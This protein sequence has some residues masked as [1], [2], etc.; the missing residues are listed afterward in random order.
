MMPPRVLASGPKPCGG[1]KALLWRKFKTQ[2]TSLDQEKNSQ[3]AS[4]NCGFFANHFC[5]QCEGIMSTRVHAVRHHDTFPIITVT[6]YNRLKTNA[7][8]TQPQQP[9]L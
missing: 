2:L 1:K 4:I 6:I 9:Q 8:V 3:H 7:I 5:Q